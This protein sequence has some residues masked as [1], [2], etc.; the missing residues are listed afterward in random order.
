MSEGVA[1]N[2]DNIVGNPAP[3][4]DIAGQNKRRDRQQRKIIQAVQDILGGELQRAVGQIR[5]RQP[6]N[7][8]RGVNRQP[9]QQQQR[10]YD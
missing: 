7:P 10:K 8:Q 6:G 5:H 1:K 2:A 4:H 9:E 3:F